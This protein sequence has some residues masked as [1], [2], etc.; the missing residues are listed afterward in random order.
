MRLNT[1]FVF[2]ALVC[3]ST[4]LHP[5][6]GSPVPSSNGM[7]GM[8]TASGSKSNA[9]QPAQSGPRTLRFVAFVPGDTSIEP[10]IEFPLLKSC[11]EEGGKRFA[12]S[13]L[14]I[15]DPIIDTD[16]FESNGA[17][18]PTKTTN[19]DDGPHPLQE[20]QYIFSFVDPDENS[21]IVGYAGVTI[22]YDVNA[23]APVED[24][25]TTKMVMYLVQYSRALRDVSDIAEQIPQPGQIIH[26]GQ[27]RNVILIAL[28]YQR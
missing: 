6:C 9:R 8:E 21:P 3:F 2:C 24:R 12:T 4:I 13:I 27:V 16:H 10:S 22:V 25:S 11:L 19:I 17:P 7:H 5:A 15:D 14:G 28:L 23:S 18:H 1:G 20:L 26:I